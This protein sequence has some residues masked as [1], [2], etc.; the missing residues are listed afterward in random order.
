MILAA[1]EVRGERQTWLWEK[2]SCGT[3]GRRAAWCGKSVLRA[4]LI[5]SAKRY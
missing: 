1:C 4:C 2:A 3:R 5:Q